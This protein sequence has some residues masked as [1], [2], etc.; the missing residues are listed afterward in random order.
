[1]IAVFEEVLDELTPDELDAVLLGVGAELL[2]AD[3][4][5]VGAHFSLGSQLEAA[6]E[7]I[8][9]GSRGLDGDLL[10]QGLGG[11][12]KQSMS[13][14][15]RRAERRVE[16]RGGLAAAGGRPNQE[17]SAVPEGVGDLGSDG[18]LNGAHLVVREGDEIGSG[19]EFG[20][21]VELAGLLSDETVEP[22]AEPGP[23]LLGRPDDVLVL[24]LGGD[25]IYQDE[26]D[27][28]RR[29]LS[30]QHEGVE[31]RLTTI[32]IEAL[33][34]IEVVEI[35]GEVERLDLVDPNR[36]VVLEYD[37]IGAA[38]EFDGPSV[39]LEL[40]LDGHLRAIARFGGLEI[41][42][43][44]SMK[45]RADPESGEAAAAQTDGPGAGFAGEIGHAGCEVPT[46]EVDGDRHGCDR[47]R[48]RRNAM[49]AAARTAA[50]IKN[51]SPGR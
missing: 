35:D 34:D 42:L 32:P 15:K 9:H 14:G 47:R 33:F 39:D 29:I 17:M 13:L 24:L 20:E 51:G 49:S 45:L 2:V 43:E 36:P 30:G 8:L 26:P 48:W 46:F 12:K 4:L 25:D 18:L 19:S 11:E 7:A 31:G 16:H 44:A 5:G 37:A 3:Q 41:R 23:H 27:R 6:E 10:L 28:G 1:M 21:S 22:L 38:D 50:A 40:E